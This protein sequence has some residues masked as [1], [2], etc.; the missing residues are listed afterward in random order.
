MDMLAGIEPC[1]SYPLSSL[2]GLRTECHSAEAGALSYYA[3]FLLTVVLLC[4]F[5]GWI[6][7]L[8]EEAEKDGGY[9]D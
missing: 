5:A 4:V 3:S 9:H 6:R 2:R 8:L 7:S 1:P